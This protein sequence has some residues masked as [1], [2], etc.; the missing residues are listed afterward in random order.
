MDKVSL[1]LGGGALSSL[2]RLLYASAAVPEP[3]SG[4]SAEIG[5][6][7]AGERRPYGVDEV[8]GE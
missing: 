6:W 3:R 5:L 7:H 8:N 2:L 1:V 4:A